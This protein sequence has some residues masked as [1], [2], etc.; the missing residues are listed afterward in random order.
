VTLETYIVDND[1][2]PG[3]NCAADWP[4]YFS[5]DSWYANYGGTTCADWNNG[6]AK[7]TSPLGAATPSGST[8]VS[9]THKSRQTTWDG[10]PIDPTWTMTGSVTYK[11]VVPSVTLPSTI[12]GP[13]VVHASVI[14]GNAQLYV[15]WVP[16]LVPGVTMT[17]YRVTYRATGSGDPFTTINVNSAAMFSTTITGLVNGQQYDVRVVARDA[18]GVLYGLDEGTGT[19][20][21]ALAATTVD[22]DSNAVVQASGTNAG[23]LGTVTTIGDPRPISL[24]RRSNAD[25]TWSTVWSGNSA[26]DGGVVVAIPVI[27][28]QHQ[29]RLSVPSAPGLAAAVSDPKWV[30]ALT[31]ITGFD[32][33]PAS[34]D[35]GATIADTVTVT[36]GNARTLEVV[37]RLVG[38]A[39]WTVHATAT[40]NASGVAAIS[41][42][43]QPGSYE[44][45][46]R[47][48]A[49]TSYGAAAITPVRTVTGLGKATSISG[50]TTASA[51][52]PLGSTVTTKVKVSKGSALRSIQVQY[53]LPDTDVW[54]THATVKTATDGS[55]TITYPVK[56][57]KVAWRLNVL[58]DFEYV[59]KATEMRSITAKTVISGFIITTVTK[60]AGTVLK[61]GFTV[62]P[63]AGRT[64]LVQFRKTG[65]STWTTAQTLTASS[66]G[67]ATASITVNKGSYEWRV[68]VPFSKF[69]GSTAATGRRTVFGT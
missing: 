26:A 12:T 50:W 41:L 14:P 62:T 24:Q 57:G 69:H 33:A 63:G 29:Y 20:N 17:G 15:S 22:W 30:S 66:T 45:A 25:G 65:T 6:S 2:D 8:T 18:A 40:A 37:K 31:T 10:Y 39:S 1:V 54:K 46:V 55:A 49:D 27:V 67:T 36:P 43:V 21:G 53:R 58:P 60:P 52:L 4:W 56:K 42:L 7:I 11:N 9:F 32:T 3:D 13:E 44:W 51:T 64:A 48:Q 38:A 19:P 5:S 35:P 47:A 34:D 16:T 61:D 28:G 68:Y 23:V 59:G